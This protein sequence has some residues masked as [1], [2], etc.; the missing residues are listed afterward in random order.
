MKK[1]IAT[2][3]SA[4]AES[5]EIPVHFPQ[6]RGDESEPRLIERSA[7]GALR[8]FPGIPRTISCDECEFI[9]S[10]QPDVLE[11][12]EISKYVESK[13]VDYRGATEAEIEKLAEEAGIGHLSLADQCVRLEVTKKLKRPK[14]E[15][16]SATKLGGGGGSKKKTGGGDSGRSSRK[17]R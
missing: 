3:V 10:E 16:A 9:R 12:L 2:L 17:P 1:C 5:V 11:R 14:P 6:K 7:F 15:N 8:F 13:R 4:P